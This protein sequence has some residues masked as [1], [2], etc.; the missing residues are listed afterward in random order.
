MA[1]AVVK[2]DGAGKHR[3]KQ[4]GAKILGR[5]KRN[6]NSKYAAVRRIT[7]RFAKRFSGDFAF[8]PRFHLSIRAIAFDLAAVFA[9][10]DR[11]IETRFSRSIESVRVLVCAVKRRSRIK[12]KHTHRCQKMFLLFD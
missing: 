10:V 6:K 3:P 12:D 5:Y 7:G 11:Q 9:A 8:R 4:N 1:F 2:K